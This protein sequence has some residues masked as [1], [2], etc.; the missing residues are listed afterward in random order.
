MSQEGDSCPSLHSEDAAEQLSVCPSRTSR[1]PESLS[2]AER[3]R[4]GSGWK[5]L[6]ASHQS[7]QSATGVLC[8]V[9]HYPKCLIK[10]NKN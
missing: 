2:S 5:G 6:V 1:L 8:S 4:S 9:E 3:E 10:Q 7:T